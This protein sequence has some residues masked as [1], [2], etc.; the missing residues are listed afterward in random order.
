MSEPDLSTTK[1]KEAVQI[2]VN[3][4]SEPETK[5]SAASSGSTQPQTSVPSRTDVPLPNHYYADDPSSW[6]SMD[7]DAAR[8]LCQEWKRNVPDTAHTFTT[9]YDF[10]ESI[11]RVSYLTSEGDPNG[12]LERKI[13]KFVW[14]ED[15]DPQRR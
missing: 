11:T 5:Q 1:G 7:D 9:D 2:G 15:P 3:T 4:V 10:L 8:K 13:E 14:K 6:P 12:R